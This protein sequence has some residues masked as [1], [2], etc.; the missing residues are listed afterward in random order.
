MQQATATRPATQHESIGVSRDLGNAQ[1]K[2]HPLYSSWLIPQPELFPDTQL[3]EHDDFVVLGTDGLWEQMCF[4]EACSAEESSMQAAQANQYVVNRVS[5]QIHRPGR[6][7][8]L[9]EA[10]AQHLVD[11]AVNFRKGLSDNVTAVVVV[12]RP[13]AQVRLRNVNSRLNLGARPVLLSGGGGSTG[14]GSGPSTPK[15]GAQCPVVTCL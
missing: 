6:M 5:N 10:A 4:R 8:D 12:L 15:G 3:T 13:W 9:V 7:Q 11:T 2:R 1:I 14:S